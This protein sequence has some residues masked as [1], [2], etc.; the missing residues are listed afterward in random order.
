MTSLTLIILF[1]S[2]YPS[3]IVMG[4][5]HYK[6]FELFVWVPLRLV[7]SNIPALLPNTTILQSKESWYRF[8]ESILFNLTEC[9]FVFRTVIDFLYSKLWIFPP[10][11]SGKFQSLLNKKSMTV[12]KTKIHSVRLNK[13]DSNSRALE[14]FLKNK[15]S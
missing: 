6:Y 4:M 7:I 9:I 10:K 12:L 13:T 5:R 1:K 8:L 14:S 11:K 2:L 15:N 3:W